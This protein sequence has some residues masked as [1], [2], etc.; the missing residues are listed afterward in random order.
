MDRRHK[1]WDGR[2]TGDGN[3]FYNKYGI[4]NGAASNPLVKWRNIRYFEGGN[5]PEQKTTQKISFP[6]IAP[7]DVE[8][9]DFD[10]GASASSG[11]PVTYRSSNNNVATVLDGRVHVVGAG[12]T[13]IE[14]YQEG[15]AVY[16]SAIKQFQKLSIENV[17][18]RKKS[19]H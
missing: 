6:E 9:A 19:I 2:Y 3:N 7:K 12:T 10:P 15:N 13:F 5:F 18:E 8:S 11:L 1:K 17:G 16:S 14:A 4:Y